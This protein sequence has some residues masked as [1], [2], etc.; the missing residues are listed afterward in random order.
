[1]IFKGLILNPLLFKQLTTTI[2]G[3]HGIT[4]L[5]HANQTNHL[6]D[7]SRIDDCRSGSRHPG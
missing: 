6:I 5:I 4:D 1:M 3:P 2:I 7:P